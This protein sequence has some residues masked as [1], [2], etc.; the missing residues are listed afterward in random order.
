MEHSNN[1]LRDYLRIVWKRKLLIILPTL[2]CIIGA[3]I[4]S[5]TLPRRWEVDCIIKLSRFFVQTGSEAVVYR[6]DGNDGKGRSKYTI[7]G[8]IRLNGAFKD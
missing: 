7:V 4:F 1:E 5:Y 8:S 2:I 6:F 3:S